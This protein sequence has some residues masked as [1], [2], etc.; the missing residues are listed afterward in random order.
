MSFSGRA[1]F[2]AWSPAASDSDLRTWESFQ[3]RVG[4]LGPLW[5]SLGIRFHPSAEIPW[6]T[7]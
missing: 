2:P 1:A 4:A 5:S 6:V 7:R 3:A